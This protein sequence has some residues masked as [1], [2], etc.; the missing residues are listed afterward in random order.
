MGVGYS[1]ST[2]SPLRFTIHVAFEKPSDEIRY[3][4]RISDLAHHPLLVKAL[5]S[6]TKGNT[7]AAVNDRY[8]RD[9]LVKAVENHI[10]SS[11]IMAGMP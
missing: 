11:D 4:W 9:L 7:L 10:R 2:S 5:I 6:G 3:P 8:W 1:A